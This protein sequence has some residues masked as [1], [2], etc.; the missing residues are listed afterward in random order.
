MLEKSNKIPKVLTVTSGKGGVGKSTTSVNVATIL[1]EM[2][3]KV[4]IVDFDVGLRKVDALMGLER[5]VFYD[6][7]QVMRGA[8]KLNSA[9]IA[10]KEIEGLWV[11]PTSNTEDKSV[12]TDENVEKLINE[13]KDSHHGFDYIICDSPAGIESGAEH[14]MHHADEAIIVVNPEIQSITDADRIIGLIDSKSKKGKNGE[15][16]PKHLLVNK[17]NKKLIKE[18]TMISYDQ[19]EKILSVKVTGLIPSEE[20]KIINSSNM[21]RPIVAMEKK[22]NVAN[23]YRNFVLRMLGDKKVLSL[24]EEDRGTSFFKNIFGG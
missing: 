16:I 9:L 24:E 20:K 4:C 18:E 17:Y 5:R 22:G 6:F 12:L 2:G 21:G 8:A 1:A 19:I 10:D 15:K 7:V 3:Y 11:L 14:A 13:L 23:A